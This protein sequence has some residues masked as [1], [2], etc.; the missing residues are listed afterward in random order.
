MDTHFRLEDLNGLYLGWM[1]LNIC[2]TAEW[3]RGLQGWSRWLALVPC[4]NVPLSPRPGPR[5][6][7]TGETFM[8]DELTGPSAFSL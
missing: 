3:S 2:A 4:Q 1:L 6:V 5:R 8:L 7:I